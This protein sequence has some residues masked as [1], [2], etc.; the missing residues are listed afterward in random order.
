MPF[1]ESNYENAVLQLFTQT[2]GYSYAYGPY[3]ERDH[4]SPLYEDELLPALR[5]VNPAMP[6]SALDDA[7]YKLKNFESGSLLQKNMVFTDYLQNG[8]PVKYVVKG[9]ERSG[10]VYLIDYRNPENN[11]FTAVNQWTVVENSEKRADVVLFINGLPLVVVELKSPSR[12]E[13]DASAAYRQLRNYMHEIPS[14]F[15]YNQICVM[16]DLTTSKAG[17]ITSGEDRF[18]EWKTKDGSYENTQYAQFDTFFEGIFEKARFLD[19]LQNFIC[20]NVDGANTF[21][22]LAGYHQYFAVKKAVESTKHATVTDG[23]GGVFWHTQGSGK[24]LSMVFYAHYLQQALESP[25]IVVITDRNDLDDQLYGQFSR[26]RDFL[27][28]TP[29][30]AESRQNL[31]ELLANRQA[32]GIIFTTMQKFEETGEAL[33]ERRNVVVM[34]DEAH[35]GQ[36]GLTEKVVTRQ[37]ERGEL[38]VRT[39]IGT[40]RIIRD[41]LPNATYIGFT[42]TPISSKDRSTREVFGDYIDIYDMTQAVEDG[43]TRPVYYESRVIHLHLDEAILHRID[44]EYDIMAQ[45]TDPYVIEKSKKELGQMEAI[46]GA[47]QTVNSLVDDI[48]DHYENY[49]AN[50]LTGKAMIV[51]YSRPIAM[52]IY[53]RILQLRPDWTEKVGVVMTQGNNDPEEWREIIGNKAH[54]EDLAR[55]FKD[56]SSPLKIAIVVDMWLTGFDVPS[57]A[58]MYV[59]KPMSGHNLMQA[60]ARVNRVFQDKEGGLVVD[61]VGIA[62]ALKQAMNDYTVRDKKNYGDPDVSKAAYPKFLEKLEVCR[63]L[64]HGFDYSPSL[65]GDDLEK[66]RMISGGVNFLLGKSVAE[67]ELPDKEKTQSVFIKEALLLKQALSL[68]GSLVDEKT[69]FES[70]YFEAVRTMLVRLT[71]GGAGK[72]LTLPEVNQR[73]NELLKHSIKSEGVINLFSDVGTEFS[74][75]DPKFLEEIAN[76]KEK[77]LAVELL[78]KLIA[79]QVSVYR[80][81]NV[82]KSEKFS[83]IIQSTMKR[84]LNGMLTNEEVIEE[85]LRLAKDIAAAKA[86]GD[87]LGLTEEELAFYD[88]L[89]K[90]QAIKDFYQNDELVAITKELTDALR[91]NRTIDWQKKESAR[92][93]MRRLV[94]RLLR[95][96]KY[97]PEG[98]ED[99]VQ[100]V[101]AQCEMWTDNAA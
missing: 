17:T 55:K 59:Y 100:T 66:A 94:K 5:A 81:T 79:D 51:A 82:V 32:N 97:P 4:R 21:K 24:S 15:I 87:K 83:E 90:P 19:I 99:A 63:D 43:A 13:T 47:E 34:A 101:M 14:L 38:E 40:A 22:I 26:C 69:R 78:K 85:L 35:R 18:M 57:L 36:Y 98:M 29:Q 74:L 67:R 11:R 31:Q 68:C 44:V 52:K 12:E 65:T 7:V 77:N 1:T 28:Q 3:V 46:L 9:E 50:L 80:R 73:I 93:G 53:K 92:A 91:K 10:L 42:G 27:R 20:F 45:N 72:K 89:T 37:N 84:Y 64:F 16:S 39:I 2:L 6:Q 61:Y 54:K 30:Q 62:A 96:H 75:F 8:V 23:K 56:N 60:I 41:S 71:T 88:A 95:K 58:T 48:L 33:S 70:A 25:T 76:M 86:E 49:R